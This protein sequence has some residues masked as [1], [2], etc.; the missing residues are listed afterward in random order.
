[1]IAQES[2]FSYA[3]ERPVAGTSI[4]IHYN[5]NHPA[6][7]LKNE[8]VLFLAVN[9][10]RFPSFEFSPRAVDLIRTDSTFC[11]KIDIPSDVM[12]LMVYCFSGST[13]GFDWTLLEIDLYDKEGRRILDRYPAYTFRN[14]WFPYPFK[15]GEKEAKTKVQEEMVEVKSLAGSDSLGLAFSLAYGYI[16]TGEIDKSIEQIRYLKEQ[17]PSHQLTYQALESFHYQA[18]AGKI[19]NSEA[20]E[21]VDS[22]LVDMVTLNPQKPFARL[23]IESHGDSD[24]QTETVERIFRNWIKDVPENAQPYLRLAA[25]YHKEKI[26]PSKIIGLCDKGLKLLLNP[27]NRAYLDFQGE[28]TKRQASQLNYY[29]AAACLELDQNEQSLVSIMAAN[30]F[31]ESGRNFILL[32]DIWMKIRNLYE[33]EKAW[34]KALQSG[35]ADAKIKLEITYKNRAGSTTGFDEYINKLIGKDSSN[36]VTKSSTKTPV[37]NSSSA[38]TAPSFDLVDM[39]GNILN[40]SNLKGKVVVLNFWSLGCG[41]CRAEIPDLNGLVKKY[42]GEEVVF[43]AL[44]PDKTKH[45]E[46]FL[47][48]KEFD[49]QLICEA[50]KAFSDFQVQVQPTHI[51]IDQDGNIYHRMIGGG[52]KNA[53]KLDGM[54]ELLLQ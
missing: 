28:M 34:T 30:Q 41:P 26:N 6:A 18:Y 35:E 29:K 5:P 46:E 40:N 22:V 19:S 54:L 25:R 11:A 44:T 51:I 50:F 47:E 8:D 13:G 23:F 1:M 45:I 7:S 15:F 53:E 49:Y 48:K 9:F 33:A 14:K 42:K 52:K 38:N 24:L 17:Y 31:M 16:I 12:Q 21:W 36:Q 20:S 10:F 3:P 4:S 32:G 27:H 43:L 39:K 37:K 2:P